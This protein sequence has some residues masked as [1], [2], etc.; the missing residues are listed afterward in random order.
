MPYQDLDISTL[1]VG[2]SA[3]LSKTVSESDVYLY[4]GITGDMNPVHIDEEYAARTAF[5]GRIAHGMLAAGFIGAVMAMKLPGPGAIYREQTLTFLAPVRIGDTITARAEIV[6]IGS[7]RK[8]AKLKTTCINQN[9][10]VVLEGMAS[11]LLP[12]KRR[13]TSKSQ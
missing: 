7:K 9:G 10:V 5:G 13:D 4:A 3:S 8:S 12:R 2:D 6:E 11:V 1:K